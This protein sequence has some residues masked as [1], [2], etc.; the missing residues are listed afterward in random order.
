MLIAEVKQTT[1]FSRDS[2]NNW[3]KITAIRREQ[4]VGAAI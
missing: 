3:K 2:N 4:T 1:I